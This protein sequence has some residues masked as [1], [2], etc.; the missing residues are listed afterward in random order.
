MKENN[1]NICESVLRVAMFWRLEHFV[2]R[3]FCRDRNPRI[4][5]H[6]V[7][8]I[9]DGVLKVRGISNGCIH[10]KTRAS[11]RIVG[12]MCLSFTRLK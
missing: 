11:G 5:E 6:L 7:T 8:W 3:E 1:A 9:C 10:A 12:F 4:V 2:M